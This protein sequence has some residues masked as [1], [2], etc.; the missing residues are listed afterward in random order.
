MA[1]SSDTKSPSTSPRNEEILV[2][3]GS[4]TG[5]SEQAAIDFCDLVPTKLSTNKITVTA[6]HMQ[7]D[8]FLEVERANWSRLVV[9]ITSS[10]GVGQA[11]LGCYR[12][13][14]L[15]D[16]IITRTNTKT[17]INSLL[18]GVTFAMLG[19]GDSKFTTY[20]ENPT[21]IHKAMCSAGAKHIG[22]LGKADA[23]SG[24]Q[25]EVIAKWID[26]IWP[27][28]GEV[29]GTNPPPVAKTTMAQTRTVELCTS[30]FPDF[31]PSP[32]EKISLLIKGAILVG[33]VSILMCI[34]LAD[35]ISLGN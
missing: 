27:L 30:V 29:V 15:C 1:D 2:L 11:P 4:Q 22:P 24:E 31:A 34:F 20:F 19:L 6:R 25:L 7:L 33:I 14:E 8:D 9:I 26:G 13:R 5:N 23:S 18:D 12:F 17:E 16:E 3:Y 21:K 28:L 10:Y 35:K 32:S